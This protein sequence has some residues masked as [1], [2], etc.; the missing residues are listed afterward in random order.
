MFQ[1][2][3]CKPVSTP[4]PLETTLTNN[5][6]SSLLEEV[7]KMKDILYHKILRSLMWL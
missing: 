3:L 5:V 7:D 2:N 1:Y 6:C 4:S